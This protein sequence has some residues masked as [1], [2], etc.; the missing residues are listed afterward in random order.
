MLAQDAKQV[1]IDTT[2]VRYFHKAERIE[3]LTAYLPDAVAFDDAYWEIHNQA[4]SRP[5]LKKHLDAAKWPKKVAP[6]LS[7]RDQVEI[8][9]VQSEWRREDKIKT[10]R[11]PGNQAHLGELSAIFAAAGGQA[12]LLIMDERR[13][14]GLAHN[15]GVEL[16]STGGLT[17]QMAADGSITV[18]DGWLVY[19]AAINR[20]SRKGFE[21]LVDDQRR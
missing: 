3:L 5:P 18:D 2:A 13:G 19:D 9:R 11:D 14:R 4:A 1:A 21:R 15:H 16:I 7:A 12:D 10:G 20:A 6:V 8:I 17:I